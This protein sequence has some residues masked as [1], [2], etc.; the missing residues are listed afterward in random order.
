MEKLTM[1]EEEVMLYIWELNECVVKDVVTRFPEPQP[2]YTTVASIVNNLKRKGY[3]HAKRY[4]NTYLYSPAVKQSEYKRN[5]MGGVVRNYFA[6]S[7][8]EMVS[9]FAK[10]Q[11]LSA[12]DLKEIISLIEKG[13]EE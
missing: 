13:K 9:F 12:D 4:G 10:E 1:Q 3:V 5:F 6:N 8:K 2:P 11:K 7:Y